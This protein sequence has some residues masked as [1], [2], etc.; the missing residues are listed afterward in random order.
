MPTKLGR[1]HI[2]PKVQC[3]VPRDVEAWIRE[4]MKRRKVRKAQIVRELIER[5]FQARELIIAGN[6]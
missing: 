1:P 5:G 2:G 3:H 6:K 4:E